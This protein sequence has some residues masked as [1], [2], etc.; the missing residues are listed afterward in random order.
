MSDLKWVKFDKANKF[1]YPTVCGYYK[2]LYQTSKGEKFEAFGNVGED[3]M[4][5]EDDQIS[6][7]DEDE[8]ED[9]LGENLNL[10]CVIL[11]YYGPIVVPPCPF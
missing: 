5:D 1:T 4:K 6:D 7:E 3:F 11:A 2:F 8:D 9:Y 10:P